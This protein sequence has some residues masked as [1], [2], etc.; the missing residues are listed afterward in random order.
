[1]RKIFL[2]LSLISSVNLYA[3]SLQD[4]KIQLENQQNIQ[5]DF[6]QEKYLKGIN[7]PLL[8]RGKFSLHQGK[9]AELLWNI[10]API[11]LQLKVN[12]HGISQWN[13][14]KQDWIA[15]ADKNQ[16]E[17][18]K[19]FL[20]ILSGNSSEL[21]KYFDLQITGDEDNWQLE[22][23]PSNNLVQQI[24]NKIIIKG[25]KNI[26]TVEILE[27]AGERTLLYFEVKK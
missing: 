2:F 11:E 5:G 24:F 12:K 1:M 6:H 25:G 10:S 13:G 15:S 21:A 16:S 4:L 14:D 26:K 19:L 8:T 27:A 20:A 18:V 17:Q 7:N 23:L 22:M 9:N 3:F